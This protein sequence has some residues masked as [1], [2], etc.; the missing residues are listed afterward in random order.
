MNK[1]IPSL[2]N[3][4]Y[5]FRK[6]VYEIL[7]LALLLK[8]K[9]QENKGKVGKERREMLDCSCGVFKIHHEFYV[10]ISVFP[11]M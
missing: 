10:T 8:V 2:F 6:V 4:R 9:V 3:I 1:R 7:V 11:L 5:R